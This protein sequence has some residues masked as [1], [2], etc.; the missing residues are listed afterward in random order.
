MQSS[1]QFVEYVKAKGVK[2]GDDVCRSYRLV[3]R[4]SNENLM[5]AQLND[6][7]DRGDACELRIFVSRAMDAEETA[8]RL[9]SFSV[10]VQGEWV[11]LDSSES[12]MQQYQSMLSSYLASMKSNSRLAW[13]KRAE[14]LGMAA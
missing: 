2:S 7:Y 11:R 9:D 13:Q 3:R 5:I 4:L 12:V 1:R 8:G 6:P 10:C 14:D